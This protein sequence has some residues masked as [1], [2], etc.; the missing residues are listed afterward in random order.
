M[1][2]QLEHVQEHIQAHVQEHVGWE[3]VFGGTLKRIGL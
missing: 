2:Y 3:E 1:R